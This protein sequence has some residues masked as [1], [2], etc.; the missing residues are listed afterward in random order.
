MLVSTEM[1]LRIT[2]PPEEAISITF[3]IDKKYAIKRQTPI[4]RKSP[5]EVEELFADKKPI[6]IE[7]N[8]VPISQGLVNLATEIDATFSSI[9]LVI[10]L[11]LKESVCD[12]ILWLVSVKP[13]ISLLDKISSSGKRFIIRV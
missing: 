6:K 5:K 8:P 1:G 3:L 9:M 7:K 2:T 13:K 10:K 12:L 4:K 11:V